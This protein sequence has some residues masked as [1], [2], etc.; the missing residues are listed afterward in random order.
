[1]KHAETSYRGYKLG[2]LFLLI[3]AVSIPYFL[4]GYVTLESVTQTYYTAKRAEADKFTQGYLKSLDF[5]LDAEQIIT[6]LLDEKI[7]IASRMTALSPGRLS[8]KLLKEL[9]DT[10]QLDQLFTYNPDGEIIYSATGE[11]IGWKAPEGHPVY[12]FMK[13][14]DPNLVEP[15]RPDSESG[16]YYKY[17]YYRTQDGYFIQ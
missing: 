3:I 11:Y 5:A 7:E 4:L 9:A 8:D 14:S 6:E 13:G 15:I 16:T 2:T 17:G 12:E 10:Y 1:V